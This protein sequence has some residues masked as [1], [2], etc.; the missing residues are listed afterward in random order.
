MEASMHAPVEGAPRPLS[1]V[2]L[3]VLLALVAWTPSLL[4]SGF[5]FDDNEALERNPIVD[6]SLP[7]QAAFERD[8]WDHLG[9]AGHYRPIAAL[10]LRFDHELH[11]SNSIGYHATNVL[12][13]VLCVA[14]AGLLLVLL[15]AGARDAPFPWF[16]LALFATHPVLA[17]SV[18]WIS[19]RTSMLSAL[20]SLAAAVWL[21]LLAV[22]WRPLRASRLV[23]AALA[24]A[25]GLLASLLAKED[26][27]VLAPALV[28]VAARHSRKLAAAAG[29]GCALA[30][31]AYGLLRSSVY[32]AWMPSAPHAPLGEF[33]LL[34]RAAF[35]GRALL[36]ALRLTAA[37]IGYPPNF[38]RADLFTSG[39]PARLGALGWLLLASALLFGVAALRRR[40]RSLA[41]LSA[42]LCAASVL[43]WMQI[44]PAGALF[45]P[46]FLYLPLLLAIPMSS[47]LLRRVA[48]GRDR[49]IGGALIA[50]CCVGAWS[51]SG[52]YANRESF[53]TEQIR[54][55]PGDARAFNELGL[56]H[57]ER[58]DV[59]GAKASYR[60]AVEL[61]PGYGRP[62][63]NL[64]RLSSNVGDLDAAETALRR[65]CEL[66]PGNAVAWSNLGAVLLRRERWT[67]AADAYRNA[68]R[69][70]ASLAPA[71]RGLARAQL[72]LG[73]LTD[74]RASI[75]KALEQDPDDVRAHSLRA[76][77]DNAAQQL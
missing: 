33:A 40:P 75:A 73:E 72:E 17:D 11:G 67:E 32:G 52:V 54:H 13:H 29:V 30:V 36:E 39:V 4:R 55:T 19:G 41:A 43:P 25:F 74:A 44:V 5:S 16:G 26:A 58:G 48:L 37:P 63:S 24:S 47:T 64:G 57:E 59:D 8:Y 68:V 23:Q 7:P 62:W 38:E 14:L 3:C 12:L 42:V 45:A 50:L 77:I 46:R 70:A 15:G 34:E 27:L 71:W 20:G 66:G 61:D 53:W 69:L 18:A 2:L 28:L 76:R 9:R 22:P 49:A 60:R 35:G 6:G 1:R 21:A 31:V 51:R 10:T 56:A 65:A